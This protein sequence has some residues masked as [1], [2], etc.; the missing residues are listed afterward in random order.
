MPQR[1][2]P[3]HARRQLAEVLCI[4]ER[5]HRD[6]NPLD[7]ALRDNQAGWPATTMH[8]WSA[9]NGDHSDPVGANAIHGDPAHEARQRLYEV[10]DALHQ[11]ALDGYHL[12][13]AWRPAMNGVRRCGNP[14]GCPGHRVAAHGRGGLCEPC[15]RSGIRAIA[16]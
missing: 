6:I 3:G 12:H 11:W 15:H 7:R 9:G 13:Q 2:T 16:A 10:I 4:V 8:E 5:L 1:R 14:D